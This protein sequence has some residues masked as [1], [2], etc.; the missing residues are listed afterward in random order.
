MKMK[1]IAAHSI[2]TKRNCLGKGSSSHGHGQ[3]QRSSQSR[4]RFSCH[5]RSLSEEM[6]TVD[7][8][9]LPHTTL[10]FTQSLL[11]GGFANAMPKVTMIPLQSAHFPPRTVVVTYKQQFHGVLEYLPRQA[12]LFALKDFYQDLLIVEGN[13]QYPTYCSNYCQNITIGGF[14]GATALC[15]FYPLDEVKRSLKLNKLHAVIKTRSYLDVFI[16]T[17]RSPMGILSLYKGIGLS[18]AGTLPYR[19]LYFGLFDSFLDMKFLQDQKG[20]PLV[21]IKL[22]MAISATLAGLY[23]AYPFETVR[24]RLQLQSELPAEKRLFSS[25]KE[26]FKWI[27]KEEGVQGLYKNAQASSFRVFPSALALLLYDELK[28]RIKATRINSD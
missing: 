27:L 24:R 18:M 22:G 15:V 26:C 2:R 20:I 14:A 11:I 6:K 21:L 5:N 19:G 17:A 7:H 13:P 25:S 1:T 16:Q 9:E 3:G 28:G 12:F 8:A 23:A 4:V 10:G